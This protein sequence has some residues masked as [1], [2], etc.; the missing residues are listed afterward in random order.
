MDYL[1]VCSVALVASALTLV[2][3]FG[4]GTLLMPA[5][6]VFFPLPAAIAATAIV[7]LASN[8]F[9]LG[10][11][12]RYADRRMLI[13]FGIPATIAALVGAA[14]LRIL[15]E[16]QPLVVWHFGSHACEIT[17]VK[18]V[19]AFLIIG[20]ALLDLLPIFSRLTIGP[21]LL[22]LGGLQSGFFGGLSGHQGTL[23]AA[24]LMRS[25]I[26]KE[27]YVGMNCVCGVMVDVARLLVYGF[28]YFAVSGASAAGDGPKSGLILAACLAAFAGSWGGSRLVK[29]V[30]F[31][32][33]RLTVAIL[34]I[35]SGIAL[36]LGL[37]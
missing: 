14:T 33:L 8:L 25:G 21:R 24:F 23:R 10:L 37:I 6:A 30:T 28:A 19:I 26:S 2:T 22:P 16:V 34:L 7:H 3:G 4:L 15:A 36:G 31:E 5:F 29:K 35:I 12:A 20:F 9:S 17:T 18:L 27:T 13:A 1:L 11:V 32:S